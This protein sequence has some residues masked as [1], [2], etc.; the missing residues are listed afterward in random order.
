MSGFRSRALMLCLTPAVVWAQA[1]PDDN[2]NAPQEPAP[3]QLERVTVSGRASLMQRFFA[4]GSLV[5]VDRQDIEQMGADS[6][7]D[8]LR[9]LPGVQVNTGA[10]GN[11]EI[12]MRGMG[13]EGTRILVD[14]EPVASR[15]GGQLPFDQLP[16]DMIERIEVVRAPSAEF[17]GASGGTIN[18]VL[19]HAT[20]KRETN[21]RLTDQ[22]VWGHN[23]VQAY[24]SRTGPLAAPQPD[25]DG[26]MQA[27]WVYFVAASSS[28]RL[29]GSDT[30]RHSSIRGPAS[31]D[32]V[33]QEKGRFR[34][35]EY[36]ASPRLSGKLGR[37][38][39]VSL[40]LFL[41]SGESSGNFTSAAAGRN[42]TGDTASQVAEHSETDRTLAQLRGEW[43]H[44]F[45]GSKLETTLSGQRSRDNLERERDRSFTDAGSGSG[46]SESLLRDARRERV[47]WLSSKLSGTEEALLWMAGGEY[48]D[49][50]LDVSSVQTSA[51]PPT[52]LDLGV[53]TQLRRAVLWG[54]N[55]WALPANTTLTVGLRAE[56]IATRSL[57]AGQQ[58]EVT[59]TFWQPS[60]H[61]RT[62]VGT[63]LQWRFNLARLTRKPAL[64]DLLD[65]RLPS[66]GENSPNNPDAVGNPQ[67]RP[68]TTTTMD[69]G[70]ERNLL[71][72]D[73]QFG[74]NVFLREVG[75]VVARRVVLDA[76]GRW[77]QQPTNVGD[78]R[79]WGVEGDLRSGLGWLGLGREWAL[80]ANAS[81][82][83]SRMLSGDMRGER[84][85]GQARYV[86]N[87]NV[88]KPLP[89]RGGWFG[90]GS[91][92]LNGA[93][94]LMTSP[95]T[96]G[97]EA[98]YASVDAYVGRVVAGLGYWRVGVYNLTDSKR[99][100][101]RVSTDAAGNT[102]TD[103]STM[104][105]TPRVFLTLGTRF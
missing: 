24:F 59:D 19:R 46:S 95:G 28:T 37:N 5:R 45:P 30:E 8:V 11:L 4:S 90:G 77:V 103:R 60:L 72:Q 1:Q 82:L 22:R 38:D 48:E 92:A 41:L 9:Q 79:V 29:A 25:E 64:A 66:Q 69:V 97:R 18:I 52:S 78:A 84:I 91:L 96:S 99:T 20:A 43:T 65:R 49:R 94:D 100:R 53:S 3:R 36:T 87:V 35:T 10:S 61:T 47:Y 13:P 27:P 101:E 89:P 86:F 32:S 50:D 17:S 55:E 31:S 70:F 83:Q 98:S 80:S 105:L 26:Q 44:R 33:A 15:R 7:G 6:V 93:A 14:G 68:E 63:D 54:Q 23:G 2:G 12:R 76:G 16:A 21:L 56:R 74:V 104:R 57:Y 85:P 88:A 34:T 51:P 40:R 81:L 62:P 75:D 39:Q 58:A 71:S 42:A 67:L 73:G 102:Y